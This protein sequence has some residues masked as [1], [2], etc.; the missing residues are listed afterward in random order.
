[1]MKSMN[2]LQLQLIASIAIPK[3]HHSLMRK[4]KSYSENV[5]KIYEP[6][7]KILFNKVNKS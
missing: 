2:N 7:I 6:K 5:F 4:S 1:M 3:E